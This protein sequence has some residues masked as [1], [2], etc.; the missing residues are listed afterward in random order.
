MTSS[1]DLQIISFAFDEQAEATLP[2]K[3]ER[4]SD[5]PAVY[6]LRNEKKKL[7]YIGE[8]LNVAKRVGQHYASPDKTPLRAQSGAAESRIILDGRF[9]KSAALD[10]EAFLIQHLASFFHG[11]PLRSSEGML[12]GESL[13]MRMRARLWPEGAVSGGR[14]SEISLSRWGRWAG[15][16]VK[17]SRM[18]V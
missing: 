1:D 2:Q 10:L 16:Q 6:V 4:L 18:A 7:A 12:A 8:S 5:W 9:N 17:A 15:R 13:R 3:D 11:A 14:F